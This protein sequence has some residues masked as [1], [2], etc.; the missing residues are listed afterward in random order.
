MKLIIRVFFYITLIFISIFKVNALDADIKIN[1]NSTDINDYIVLTISIDTSWWN[2]ILVK[3]V[4]W[5]ENFELINQTQSKKSSSS[6][7]IVNWQTKENTKVIHNLVLTLKWKDKGNYVLWPAIVQEGGE[8]II[9][10]SV[11]IEITWDRLFL[12]NN[13]LNIDLSESNDTVDNSVLDNNK[14]NHFKDWDIISNNN[15][16]NKSVS[17]SD[18]DIFILLLSLLVMWIILYFFLKNNNELIWKNYKDIKKDDVNFNQNEDRLE[19]IKEKEYT[20]PDILSDNFIE[21][22]SDIFKTKIAVKYGIKSIKK[23]SW[24]EILDFIRDKNDISNVKEIIL[25][26]NKLKYSKNWNDGKIILDK[27][28]NI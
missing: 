20:Y 28:K 11:E 25:L 17:E 18:K 6:I 16:I 1:T 9:T 2:D 12:N 13:H 21:E 19:L 15:L 5:L 3:E 27:V 4:K 7:V 26:L 24:E 14:D 10:N 22:I 23:L 8:E